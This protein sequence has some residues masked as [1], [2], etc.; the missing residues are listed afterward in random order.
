MK[1][2]QGGISIAML[3]TVAKAQLISGAGGVDTGN[4]AAVP[5]TNGF[6]SSV[7]E[8]HSDDHSADVDAK[9]KVVEPHGR[10][11]HPGHHWVRE[12]IDG[13]DTGA[14]YYH[15]E[16]NVESTSV[17]ESHQGDHSVDINEDNV[18]VL[19]P[20]HG[21]H[22]HPHEPT[23]HKAR[24]VDDLIGG[25]SGID[26]GNSAALP[27]TNGFSSSVNEAHSDD[28]SAAVHD[29]KTVVDPEPHRPHHHW[30]REEPEL[31]GGAHGIDTG[32]SAVIPITNEFSSGV[33]EA[34][35]DDH[36][37]DLNKDKT[38][39]DSDHRPHHHWPR[40]EPDLIGGT[41]G[42]DTANSA[43]IPITNDFSSA[44]NE[45]HADDHTV[46][47]NKDKTVVDGAHH[48]PHHWPR[49]EADLIG[50]V[51][52]T[53]TSGSAAVPITNTF[54]SGV[55]E[56]HSDD[57]S[58]DVNKD[59][60]VVHPEDHRHHHH[61]RRVHEDLIS[62]AGGIDTGNS[63]AIP[64]T[65]GFSS[66]VNEASADDHS[67][68]LDKDKTIVDPEHHRDFT[69]P[70]HHVRGEAGGPTLL[71]GASGVD[72]ANGAAIPITNG[73]SSSVN[74][75]SSDDH[76]VDADFKDTLVRPGVHH[77][78]HG[79]D[80][81]GGPGG[82][83]T[84]NS[85]VIPIT[86][87]FASSDNE[88]SSDDHS[89]DVNSKDTVVAPPDHHHP[90]HVPRDLISG[91]SGIDTGNSA[92]L[93]ITNEF[94]SSY[95][96]HSSDDHSA[97]VNVKD[98]VIDPA[99]RH[100]HPHVPRDLIS[101][102]SGID[103]GNSATLPFTN[104]A[105]NQVSEAHSD[106]HSADVNVKDTVV[107][108]KVHGHHPHGPRDLFGG[109]SGIDTGNSVVI[110]ITN[111]AS[112]EVSEAHSDDHA[113]DVDVKDTVVAPTSPH[114]PHPHGPRDL[115]SG[116]GGV[117]TGNSAVL[118]ITNVATSQVSKVSSDDH[119][120]DAN[121]KDTLVKPAPPHHAHPHPHL[122][123]DLISG[124]GGID[125]GNSAAI[126]ITNSF[127]SKVNEVS[128]DD[129]SVDANLKDT[130]V[131]E[132]AH[133]H[134]HARPHHPR[135]LISGA[136]GID[137]GNSAALP[138]TNEFSSEVNEA[139]ADDHSV[140][141]N[142]KDTVVDQLPHGHPHARPHHA[143]NLISG[144]GG[145]D[146]GNSAALPFTNTF[147]SEVN[148]AHADDHSVDADIKD[149]LVND[150]HRHHHRAED[151]L[152]SGV[153]GVDTGNSAVIPITN[154]YGKETNEYS[155]DD[156]SVSEDVHDT[157]VDPY[158]GHPDYHGHA[159][160]GHSSAPVHSTDQGTDQGIGHATEQ[161]S[162]QTETH[163][164]ETQ[165]CSSQ[166]V[167]E[168][169]HTITRTLN[170]EPTKGAVADHQHATP[171]YNAPAAEAT[172][173]VEETSAYNAPVAAA[174]TPVYNAPAEATEATV[175]STP[176]Y[177]APAA[178]ESTVQYAP[179]TPVYNEAEVVEPS[180]GS[181]F[182][183]PDIAEAHNLVD[184][185]ASSAAQPP[186][187]E[188]TNAAVAAPAPT[189]P[190]DVDTIASTITIQE[191]S[192][193]HMIPV[194]VPAPTDTFHVAASS[195]AAP[196]SRPTG[197][198]ALPS[199]RYNLPLSSSSALPSSNT[200]MFTGAGAQVSPT[201]LFPI[202]AGLVALLAL[203]L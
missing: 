50:G 3:A 131:D 184:N 6:S 136:G 164:T 144:A 187:A 43:A 76:S 37:V 34:H 67:V 165:P 25:E 109:A 12:E 172:G 46:D 100:H 114:H 38:V 173:A 160:S 36:S 185:S 58:V 154:A 138:F 74:E 139:H 146:T 152:I 91:A 66:T 113:A 130:V 77:P 162:D 20:D 9:K 181:T 157:V 30:P 140:D 107:D 21:H 167:H 112:N 40:G 53:D 89:A 1:G 200:I 170:S 177:Q 44:V 42:I 62:G 52:G 90:H 88:V 13:K 70:H 137:T 61:W 19:K 45:A 123:R 182:F 202:V 150:P 168:V 169:V 166:I 51:H 129:H 128:S 111:V 174:S 120:V 33:N 63:A 198:D 72:T 85:V 155:S 23:H 135:D 86:N 103:T 158:H 143:R 24:G 193:F 106:D 27:L 78:H 82:I 48:R 81:F 68:K 199:F 119:S 194:F 163:G 26:T 147:S 95:N 117:D 145:I 121:I 175:E 156:H 110:P 84:G 161:T 191:A 98:T 7:N 116:A 142:L 190:F 125:T 141:A 69:H 178:I 39:V 133:G 49:E 176:V 47:L 56:K 4:T 16:T 124:A 197:V 83:D 17:T 18:K 64:I 22:P 80:L 93:P 192:T 15:P 102:A 108:P 65:N 122:P 115:I 196:S 186:V 148:E 79:R 41:H 10:P 201:G 59:K 73:F 132:S 189:D 179:S 188:A 149:T 195:I 104:L 101:G 32:N 127:S 180:G 75:Y 28:H 5:I 97:D 94:A 2:L 60:T 71:G 57:H 134:P 99:S 11:G 87:A 118:P 203:V 126:P 29:D 35:A 55:S 105:S 31:F 171:A 96:D 92:V 183:S 153:S 14:Q 8:A 54:S 159:D 151:S